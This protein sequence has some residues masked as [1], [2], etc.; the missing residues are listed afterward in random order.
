MSERTVVAIGGGGFGRVPYDSRLDDYLLSLVTTHGHPDVSTFGRNVRGGMG[1][2]SV[3]IV[4]YL[5]KVND[6]ITCDVKLT[7]ASGDAK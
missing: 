5:K 1:K 2:R 4:K 7:C 3:L 6:G